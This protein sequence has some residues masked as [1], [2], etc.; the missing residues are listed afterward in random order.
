[1]AT[2]EQTMQTPIRA[3]RWL[4]IALVASLALNLLVIGM[5]AAAMFHFKRGHHDFAGR[6]REFAQ[7]L[8]I[9]RQA[10]FSALIDEQ[11]TILEPLRQ[12]AR[13]AR[14][15]A[16]DAFATEPFDPVKLAEAYALA[17]AA[18]QEMATL[19]AAWLGKVGILLNAEERQK[20][21]LQGRHGR[22]H[23]EHGYRQ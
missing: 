2:T 3:P 17:A 18:R 22:H 19:R 9:D 7:E 12:R 23:G 10:A 11:R 21:L 20:F 1:M 13:L 5:A 15:Q 8:P 14:R 6:Y 16:K 4:W